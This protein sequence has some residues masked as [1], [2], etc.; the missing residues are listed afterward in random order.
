MSTQQPHGFEPQ[1]F[2]RRR[3][4]M[5]MIGVSPTETDDA[6]GTRTVGGLE[7]FDEF[8]PFVAADQRVNLVEAQ[9]GD[10]NAGGC[11][12]VELKRL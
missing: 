8:E 11:E 3:Q 10:F 12:P 7:V 2:S 5:Q 1:P 6:F 4:R 9:D